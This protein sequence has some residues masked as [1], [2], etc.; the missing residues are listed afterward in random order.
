MSGLDWLS[1]RAD[2]RVK[3]ARTRRCIVCK[4]KPG[5]DCT[6]IYGVSAL[7]GRIVHFARTVE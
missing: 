1:N 4:V 7:K 6:D 3:T 5:E 2:E